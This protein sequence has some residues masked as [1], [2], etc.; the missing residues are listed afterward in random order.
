MP[1]RLNETELAEF[2]YSQVPIEG[3]ISYREL[4]AKIRSSE[5]PEALKMVSYLKKTGRLTARL[6]VL[7]NGDLLHVYARKVG[8]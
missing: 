6:E 8:E 1:E 7:P 2:A 5:Q 4:W 3:E